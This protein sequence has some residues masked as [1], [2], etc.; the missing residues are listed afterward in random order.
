L[1]IKIRKTIILP[2]VLYGYE[3]WSESRDSSVDI[4]TGYGLAYRMIG[5]R[6]PAGAGNF[7]LRH[8]VQTGSG[9]HPSSYP[10]GTGG[11]FPEGKAARAWSWPLTSI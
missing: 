11:S 8:R 10:M 3:N 6:F 9:T 5:V 2:L 1:K 4:V 7:P